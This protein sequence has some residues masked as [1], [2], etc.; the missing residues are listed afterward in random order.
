MALAG[1][2]LVANNEHGLADKRVKRIADDN[3][4]RQTSDIMRPL[5]ARASWG[6]RSITPMKFAAVR[7]CSRRSP[8]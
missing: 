6:P 7:R 1:M 3:L 4:K 8:S 5:R 2:L